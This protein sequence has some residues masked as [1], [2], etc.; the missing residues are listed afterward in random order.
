MSQI[1]SS[2]ADRRSKSLADWHEAIQNKIELLKD[3][4]AYTGSLIEQARRAK[5][6]GIIS[7][8]ELRELVELAG[9]AHEWAIEEL[10]VRE[11]NHY[12]EYDG[13]F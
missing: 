8:D 9:A 11:L 2:Q 6:Q 1:L 7:D 10:L 3:P 13:T 12:G 5:E 4:D